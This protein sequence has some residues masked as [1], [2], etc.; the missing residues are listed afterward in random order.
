MSL[1]VSKSHPKTTVFILVY[2]KIGENIDK[3]IQVIRVDRQTS[4]RCVRWTT[5]Q[6]KTTCK[7]LIF[8]KK[9]DIWLS[10]QL[11][12]KTWWF[13]CQVLGE[14]NE[15]K[16]WPKEKLINLRRVVFHQD[17]A[18]A[19]VSLR[20]VVREILI[21]PLSPS[22]YHVFLALEK[23]NSWSTCHQEKTVKIRYYRFS[24]SG[25][26]FS[27]IPGTSRGIFSSRVKINAVKMDGSFG[28]KW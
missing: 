24:P 19:L 10:P 27:R 3:T 9:V 22:A 13:T 7:R 21:H 5:K 14:R 26:G 4:S 17:N 20:G 16:M 25:P 23:L 28:T 12:K 18:K 8:Q 11:T 6:F 15:L 1:I 2:V